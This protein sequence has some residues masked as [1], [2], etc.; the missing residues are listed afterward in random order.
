MRKIQIV[1]LCR[2]EEM[3][4]FLYEYLTELSEFDP[5][6]K[7][8]KTGTPIYKWFDCYFEDRDRFPLYLIVDDKVAGIAMIRELEN[9]LYEF[10]EFYVCP[11]FRKDGNALWFAKEITNLFEGQFV[12][13]TRFT[14]P[15]AIK[16][17]GKFAE[18]FELN[19]YTD[20]EIWRN[21]TIRKN[22]H[23]THHL[24]LNP[25]YFELIKDGKKTLEGR[26]NDEKRK[27]FNIGDKIV[28]HKEPERV[29]IVNAIILNKY[30]FKD[31]KEMAESL[32]KSQLGFADKTKDEMINTYRTIYTVEDEQQYGVVIFKIK[33]M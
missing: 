21:W 8:D 9:M 19:E 25:I 26:L 10:A 22:N 14:N 7:F 28:F 3:R 5:D 17:W 27:Q 13:A 6:I 20:D 18:M 12:F 29:E 31:F 15:R 30:I 1:P 24:N 32:D 2:M 11:K 4:K 16:F 33:T 23:K